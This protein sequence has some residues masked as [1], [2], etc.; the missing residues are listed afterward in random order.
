MAATG[1]SA[2]PRSPPGASSPP[3]RWRGP[4]FL[5]YAVEAR[6]STGGPAAARALRGVSAGGVSRQPEA[7]GANFALTALAGLSH[8]AVKKACPP[9]T[10]TRSRRIV[11]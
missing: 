8:R 7:A 2:L 10:R 6:R 1:H 11:A 4:A 3:A 5:V 9:E